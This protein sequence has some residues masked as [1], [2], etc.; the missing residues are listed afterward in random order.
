MSA[1]SLCWLV[2]F[3]QLHPKLA[4]QSMSY[5]S[6]A[7]TALP[8]AAQQL[9]EGVKVCLLVENSTQDHRF[10]SQGLHGTPLATVARPH[11]SLRVLGP[12]P[13]P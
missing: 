13:D 5:F 10:L 8:R 12:T 7:C 9:L 6:C 2:L 4:G 11:S 3:P 1:F